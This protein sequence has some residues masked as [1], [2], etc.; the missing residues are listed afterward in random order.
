MALIKNQLQIS[1]DELRE[2]IVEYMIAN[3]LRLHSF[4][5]KCGLAGGQSIKS[6]LTGGN[7]D[8]MTKIKVI[9][10]MKK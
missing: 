1:D 7:I 8:F 6:F 10:G 4:G 3:S 5:K 2:K 9:E